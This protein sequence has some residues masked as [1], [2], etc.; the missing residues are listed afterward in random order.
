MS[1]SMPITPWK[2]IKPLPMK[3]SLTEPDKINSNVLAKLPFP[4]GMT[5]TEKKG[6]SGFAKEND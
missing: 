4:S 5:R 1:T 2:K 6:A 3:P